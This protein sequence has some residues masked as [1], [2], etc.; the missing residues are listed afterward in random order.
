M[1]RSFLA[2]SLIASLWCLCARGQAPAE[3][4]LYEGNYEMKS[5]SEAHYDVRCQI[6]VNSSAGL[7][8]AVFSE[9]T[10]EFKKLSSFSGSITSG[11]KV[12]QK[13]RKQDVITQLQTASLAEKTYLNLYEPTAP[14]PF[15][16]EYSYSLDYQKAIASFPS[17]SPVPDYD[18]PVRK[19]TYTLSVPASIPIQYKASQEPVRRSEKGREIYSWQM[20]NV[21]PTPM[22][23]GMPEWM[24]WAPY[25]YA[26]PI[27]FEYVGTTGSQQTWKDIGQWNY[28]ILPKDPVLPETLRQAVLSMISKCET[29]LDKVVSLYGYL[30]EHTR[31][32]SIQLGIGGYV[33]ASPEEVARTGFG[34]CKALSFYMKQLLALAGISS[35]Y[36]IV[37]TR[38]K[39]LLPDYASLGQMNHALLRVPLQQDTIWVECTNPSLPLGYCHSGIAGHEALLILPEGGELVRI[40][41]PAMQDNGEASSIAVKLSSNGSATVVVQET[42]SAGLSESYV[43]FM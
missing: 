32:V 31:Y 9:F 14:Y 42:A 2:I 23:S 21:P 22:E 27:K 36:A 24:E 43:D 13:L 19:A 20:L 6:R 15:I 10:D 18:I 26:C 41:E 16:V 40:G 12:V 1:N 35:D 39:D 38:R 5:P 37:S 34:D 11:G 8:A 25:V 33:P 4:L 28:D 29:D 7:E 3:V 17:F 30:R